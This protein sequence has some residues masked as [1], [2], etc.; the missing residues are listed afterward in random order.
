V[1]A[2]RLGPILARKIGHHQRGFI[3]GRDGRENII[4]M[5][6][7]INMIN[8]KNEERAVA[9]LDQKKEFDMVSFTTINAIFC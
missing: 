2:N 8:S 4:N 6:M 9:F 7:I 1:W 5:Q 3:P